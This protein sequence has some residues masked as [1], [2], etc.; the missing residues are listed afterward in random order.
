[1]TSELMFVP[2]PT[3]RSVKVDV[4]ATPIPQKTGPGGRARSPAL[5]LKTTHAL[6]KRAFVDLKGSL[7][8]RFT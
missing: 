6:Y 2:T 7:S 8:V 4:E 3:V 1:M 5:W